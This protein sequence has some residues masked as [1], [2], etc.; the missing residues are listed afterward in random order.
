MQQRKKIVPIVGVLTILVLSTFMLTVSAQSATT[1]TTPKPKPNFAIA[2]DPAALIIK[3][4][5]SKSV[6][7]GVTAL[8]G[9]KGNV[10]LTLTVS[11]ALK[12]KLSQNSLAVEAKTAPLKTSHLAIGV[13]PTTKPGTY[14]I[15]VTA[16]FGSIQHS[17][18][19]TVKV[20]K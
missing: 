8:N 16:T 1:S 9:F 14:K 3:A 19:V 11:P 15:M 7:I 6:L 10:V 4:G 5:T 13:P 18:V 2:A 20:S 17:A 12:A